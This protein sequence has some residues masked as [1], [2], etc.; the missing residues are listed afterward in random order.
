[1][2]ETESKYPR[3]G[4]QEESVELDTTSKHRGQKTKKINCNVMIIKILTKETAK[5]LIRNEN[6]ELAING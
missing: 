5:K 4:E 2:R 6:A 1:M 3:G